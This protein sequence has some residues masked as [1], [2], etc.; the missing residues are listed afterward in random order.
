M[1]KGL[2][3]LFLFGCPGKVW[4]WLGAPFI[5]ESVKFSP[6]HVSKLGHACFGV[7]GGRVYTRDGGVLV[8]PRVVSKLVHAC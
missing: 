2:G 6:T 8:S 3:E 1:I 5:L 7:G 4:S